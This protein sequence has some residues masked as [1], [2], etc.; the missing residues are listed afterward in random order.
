MATV[1]SL[2]TKTDQNIIFGVQQ[3]K[4]KTHKGLEQVEGESL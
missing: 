2:I 3:F 1:N 4:K